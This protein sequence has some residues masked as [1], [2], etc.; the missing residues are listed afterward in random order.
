MKKVRNY[1]LDVLIIVYAIVDVLTSASAGNSNSQRSKVYIILFTIIIVLFIIIALRKIVRL[2]SISKCLIVY[3]LYYSVD[4]FLIKA[5]FSW[6]S[7]SHLAMLLWWLFTILYFQDGQLRDKYLYS[8]YKYFFRI[9]FFFYFVV[10]FYSAR[11]ISLN[12]SS[13]T[14]ARVGYIYHIIGL[15]PF[16]L[17]E[18][19]KK[20]K[21]VFLALTV[22]S[23]IFSFKRG[24]IIMLPITL[25]VYFVIDNKT[26]H[27]KNN[28]LLIIL[29]IVVFIAVWIGIDRYSN[30]YLSQR[31]TRVELADGS[32]RANL[33]RVI[34]NNVS[35]RNFLQLL[36]GVS[37]QNEIQTSVG[38]HNEWISQIFS[39]GVIGVL[40]YALI[41]IRLATMTIR[42]IKSKSIL[43]AP[44][45]AMTVY[46]FGIGMVSG[47]LYM[48][49]TFYIMVF[50][51]FVLGMSNKTEDEIL[52]ILKQKR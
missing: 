31:F 6:N 24:A 50:I 32:G 27:A 52:E 1:I 13:I 2:D 20:I 11:N 22:L 10:I 12:Y 26:K 16:M 19:N 38:A 5:S 4:V 41:M 3:L 21:Y 15:L 7:L 43:A 28:I 48:H 34:I 18:Q 51:G 33:L 9:M 29:I 40:F 23:A 14:Y 49:S 46:S 17:L 36:F 47:W 45:G 44:F 42:L 8:H 35:Q 25:L 37:S 39:Y 30:G